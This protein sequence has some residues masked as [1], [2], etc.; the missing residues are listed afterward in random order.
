MV[1]VLEP[2]NCGV[3]VTQQKLTDTN[4]VAIYWGETQ[5]KFIFSLF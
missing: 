3:V 4:G 2:L 1:I 5:L